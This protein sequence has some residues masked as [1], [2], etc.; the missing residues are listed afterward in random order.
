MIP[1]QGLVRFIREQSGDR[2]ILCM[3]DDEQCRIGNQESEGR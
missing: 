3:R 2:E 1:P